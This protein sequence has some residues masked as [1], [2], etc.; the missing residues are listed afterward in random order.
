MSMIHVQ[1]VYAVHGLYV[2]WLWP[3][4]ERCMNCAL[5]LHGLNLQQARLFCCVCR[6]VRPGG[7]GN[8]G[9]PSGAGAALPGGPPRGAPHHRVEAERRPR[10]HDRP[11]RA[12][13]CWQSRPVLS[14]VTVWVFLPCFASHQYWDYPMAHPE[15]GEEVPE[16]SC[17]IEVFYSVELTFGFVEHCHE[18]RD[19]TFHGCNYIRTDAMKHITCCKW[20]VIFDVRTRDRWN[21]AHSSQPYLLAD[22]IFISLYS[23]CCWYSMLRYE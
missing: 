6:C 5:V 18:S 2:G 20:Y 9:G 4:C 16:F 15:P 8:T 23:L 3:L 21:E 22:G 11:R 7:G 17:G 12:G 14:A 13:V 10:A 19:P 1:I